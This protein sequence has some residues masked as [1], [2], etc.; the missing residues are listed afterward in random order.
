MIERFSS[1][2][3]HLLSTYPVPG[4]KDK[5]MNQF[6]FFPLGSSRYSDGK[7]LLFAYGSKG[8]GKSQCEA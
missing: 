4:T 7:E 3:R 6:Y 8:S 5:N 1:F 2:N